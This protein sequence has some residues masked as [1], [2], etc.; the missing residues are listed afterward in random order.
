MTDTRCILVVE[1]DSILKGLLGQSL[2]D[3][4]QA[5][6]AGDG[7]EAI[8]FF[9]QYRPSLVLLDLMLPTM[10][11]YAVLETIRSR[12]DSLRNVPIIVVSNQGQGKEKDRAQSLGATEYLVR[13]DLTRGELIS[14][15]QKITGDA[16]ISA[17]S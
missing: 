4:F 11:G 16:P 14:R 10:D 9:E 15:I 5:V 6:Y 13:S 12:N 7:N 8:A 1:D 3:G 2:T 17:F